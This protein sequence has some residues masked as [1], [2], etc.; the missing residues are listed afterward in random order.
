MDVAER[1]PGDLQRQIILHHR[2]A[3][4][5]HFW[6]ALRNFIKRFDIL[7]YLSNV[8]SSGASRRMT[9][10]NLDYL[11]MNHNPYWDTKGVRT[12]YNIR[13]RRGA[14]RPLEDMLGF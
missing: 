13:S 3:R 5:R 9:A 12:A 7:Y 8:S 1:L 6:R 10:D 2:R 4:A 14:K 11:R